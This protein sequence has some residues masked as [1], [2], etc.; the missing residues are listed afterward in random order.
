MT[1]AGDWFDGAELNEP[2]RL[3]IGRSNAVKLFK[4]TL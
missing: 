2:D 1:D 4:L 3:K